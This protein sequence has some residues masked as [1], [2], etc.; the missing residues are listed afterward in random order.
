MGD[1]RKGNFEVI[2]FNRTLRNGASWIVKFFHDNGIEN[3]LKKIAYKLKSIGPLNIQFKIKKNLPI[4]FEINP[5]FSGSCVF[6]SHYGFNEIDMFIDLLEGKDLNWR[7]INKDDIG[8]R[9]Y[10]D[11][12]I[13]KKLC[14]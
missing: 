4:V 1:Y 6:R 2:I 10:E 8:I 11:Y 14:K 7:L 5:R 13:K 3:E 9:Y 12:Y